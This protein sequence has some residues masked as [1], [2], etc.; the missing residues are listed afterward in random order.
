MAACCIAHD[1]QGNKEVAKGNRRPHCASSLT[2]TL[3]N[4]D[5]SLGTVRTR[6]AAIGSY[7]IVQR[8]SAATDAIGNKI[9]ESKAG[10]KSEAYQKKAESACDG[11]SMSLISRRLIDRASSSVT[12][13]H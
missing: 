1:L 13:L 11:A 9:D 8:A 5:A 3:G 6:S 2:L 10:T 4:T 12:T 7:L